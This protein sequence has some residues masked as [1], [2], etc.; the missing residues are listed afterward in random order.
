MSEYLVE[1]KVSNPDPRPWDAYGIFRFDK[2]E[3]HG[4]YSKH[5]ARL[6][7]KKESVRRGGEQVKIFKAVST[8]EI[9]GH[10]ASIWK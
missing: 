8:V 2:T 6:A 10:V 4:P 5:A 3:Y 9:P 1:I 7:A